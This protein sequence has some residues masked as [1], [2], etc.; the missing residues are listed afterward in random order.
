[1][2]KLGTLLL[3]TALLQT[4]YQNDFEENEV[5]TESGLEDVIQNFFLSKGG[6]EL[7]KALLTMG[8]GNNANDILDGL[9]AILG[10]GDGIDPSF[11][12]GALHALM[13]PEE[14]K[15]KRQLNPTFSWILELFA[16][17][18]GAENLMKF[19][20]TVVSA[21][22]SFIT[23]MGSKDDPSGNGMLYPF[24]EKGR[25][26][27]DTF[28]DS[29]TG[30][31]MFELLRGT[32]GYNLVSD[33]DGSFSV[34]K[35][36]VLLENHSFRKQG[37]EAITKK[38]GEIGA[39]FFDPAIRPI[40]LTTLETNINGMLKQRGF[41]KDAVFDLENPVDSLSAIINFGFKKAFGY[42]IRSKQ[43]VKPTIKYVKSIYNGVVHKGYFSGKKMSAADLSDN[44]ADIIN[45]EIIE[46]FTRVFRAYRFA[47]KHTKCDKYVMCILNKDIVDKSVNLPI[48]KTW[49]TKGASLIGS[50]FISNHT[51]TSYWTFY[52]YVMDDLDCK[53]VHF[54]SCDTFHEEEIKATTKLVHTEL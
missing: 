12:T 13:E 11:L 15:K 6:Q 24:I 32:E 46:P 5:E 50:W 51:G 25:E 14:P 43:Y 17:E 1:M 34:E 45:L 36:F 38:I 4:T 10:K 26:L 22:N 21:V 53:K 20:P 19:F 48:V 7:G 3:V 37:I 30:R 9:G 52:S 8:S 23:E 35:L 27:L 39:R 44:L 18:G 33:K 40:L 41:P 29:Q 47:K 49:L 2:F 31:S 42:Q 54:K 16:K 28:A